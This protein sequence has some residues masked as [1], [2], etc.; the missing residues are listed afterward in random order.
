MIITRALTHDLSFLFFVL[1]TTGKPSD[2]L[3]EQAGQAV[4]RRAELSLQVPGPVFATLHLCNKVLAEVCSTARL[5]L[6][7]R[8][9]ENS[10]HR[11]TILFSL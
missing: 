4:H 10:A 1:G 7:D 8:E 9:K 3:W 11:S 2:A 5:D 6:P